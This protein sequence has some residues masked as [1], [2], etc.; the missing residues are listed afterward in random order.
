VEIGAFILMMLLF[1]FLKDIT[2]S[3][4]AMFL[5]M[6]DIFSVREMLGLSRRPRLFGNIIS[7]LTNTMAYFWTAMFVFSIVISM[8]SGFSEV[9][10]GNKTFNP[11]ENLLIWSSFIRNGIG[12]ANAAKVCTNLRTAGAS[13]PL[14][15]S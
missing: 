6:L 10:G 9:T 1:R 11:A 8:D 14:Q 5:N 7:D 2:L 12:G 4:G 15:R 3:Y 13:I